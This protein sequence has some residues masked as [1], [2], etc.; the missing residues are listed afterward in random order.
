MRTVEIT[1]SRAPARAAF[2][3]AAVAGGFALIASAGAQAARDAASSSGQDQQLVDLIHRV[4]QRYRSLNNFR[5]TFVQ[6]LDSPTFGVEEQARG[7][8][9]VAA[10]ARML[11]VYERPAGQTAVADATRWVLIDHEEREL[12]IRERSPDEPQ[13][14]ADLLVGTIDLLRVFAARPAKASATAAGRTVMELVPREVLEEVDLV[15]LEADIETADLRRLELIDPSDPASSSNSAHRSRKRRSRPSGSRS[16]CPTDTSS[17]ANDGMRKTGWN[18]AQAVATVLTPASA[19]PARILLM[20]LRRRCY[21]A[22][23]CT[24]TFHPAGVSVRVLIAR[25]FV[26]FVSSVPLVRGDPSKDDST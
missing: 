5:M 19:A 6:S 18:Q 20:G 23:P 2:V 9:H 11:W 10:P 12:I 15:L 3:A 14:L 13:P 16:M 17:R 1:R 22:P 21:P 24:R 26:V 7:V 4:E 25:R 8:L